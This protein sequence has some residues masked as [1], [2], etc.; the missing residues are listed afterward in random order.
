MTL[1]D[2]LHG[3]P[4]SCGID[5]P[6]DDPVDDPAPI[7]LMPHCNRPHGT[8]KREAKGIKKE[9]GQRFYQDLGPRCLV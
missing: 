2:R 4:W 1:C 3:P 5:D 9:E 8:E 6:V 7:P